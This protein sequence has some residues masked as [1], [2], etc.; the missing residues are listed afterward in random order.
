MDGV[1][2][3]W[4]LDLGAVIGKGTWSVR[5]AGT[6]Y[7]LK[8]LIGDWRYQ[9]RVAKAL[10]ELGWPTPEPAE[11]P[12]IRD[13]GAWVLF[14]RLPGRHEEPADRDRGR[15]LAEL[16]ADARA[17]GITEQR[18]G[19][20]GPAEVVA[21]P[22][23]ERSLRGYGRTHPDEARELLAARDDTVAWFAGHA[24]ID[25]PRSVIHGDFTPWNLLYQNGRLSGLVDFEGTHHTYQVADFA[26]S[27]RGYRD[28]VL[29]GYDEV[30]P[31]AEVEW[32]L[33]RPVYVAWLFLGVAGPVA[34]LSWQVAH[35]RKHSALLDG[36]KSS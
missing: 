34:D 1:R 9:L 4:R 7:V 18:A 11:E 32:A 31:L 17:T 13:D 5:R 27:W 19:F 8:L 2:A 30:R 28:D 35:L 10:R 22:A 26:L 14:H 3:I 24:G 25:A 33:I 20:R 16:H 29:R 23:L 15:L 12:L 36:R 6:A 21:D